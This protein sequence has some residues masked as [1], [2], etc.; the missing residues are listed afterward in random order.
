MKL[1]T[2]ISLFFCFILIVVIGV[3]GVTL[4]CYKD[5]KKDNKKESKE[6]TLEWGDV[7]LKILKDEENFKDLEDVKLQ[8]CDIDNNEVPELIVYGEKNSGSDKEKNL[9]KIYRINDDDKVDTIQF[10]LEEEFGMQYLYNNDSKDANWYVVTDEK[11]I[12]YEIQVEDKNYE[13]EKS[14]YD[15]TED[16]VVVNEAEKIEFDPEN[17]KPKEVIKEVKEAYV[18][19]KEFA[20]EVK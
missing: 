3:A 9:A 17:D 18:P 12:V 8:I 19:T 11:E 7:Y 5:Y 20:S 16:F 2:K 1:G 4:F 6:E 10:E 14:E 15:Y 13:I